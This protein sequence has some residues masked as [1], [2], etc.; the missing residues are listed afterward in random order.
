M[1]KYLIDILY[2][3]R[4]LRRTMYHPVLDGIVDKGDADVNN[5]IS[6]VELMGEGQFYTIL[7]RINKTILLAFNV[8]LV[9]KIQTLEI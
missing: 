2:V 1:E 3:V 6:Y 8:C 4:M 9:L 5:L 7:G